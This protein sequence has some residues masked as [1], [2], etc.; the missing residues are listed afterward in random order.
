MDRSVS[1]PRRFTE[2]RIAWG[3]N[4]RIRQVFPVKNDPAASPAPDQIALTHILSDISKL[5][6]IS[7]RESRG[8]PSIES[9][10]GDRYRIEQCFVDCHVHRRRVLVVVIISTQ[11]REQAPCRLLT[12]VIPNEVEESLTAS[13]AGN[14]ESCLD[15]ARHD[16]YVRS[17]SR[18]FAAA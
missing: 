3:N 10:R 8:S 18:I 16:N 17:S 2:N 9:N 7:K 12:F 4:N 11:G 13:G 14:I 6:K 5:S 15:F 1:R